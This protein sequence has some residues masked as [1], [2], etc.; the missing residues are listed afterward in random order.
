MAFS[1]DFLIRK[2][3]NYT[4]KEGVSMIKS[5]SIKLPDD[6]RVRTYGKYVY[7][8]IP[9]TWDG[10]R[11]HSTDDRKMIGKIDEEKPGYFLP[12]NIYYEFFPVADVNSLKEPD[13]MDTYLAAGPFLAL[14]SSLDKCGALKA[15]QSTFG[16]LAPEIQAFA[17]FMVDTEQGRA[18][19]Y[20]RWGFSNYAGIDHVFSTTGVSNLF[21]SIGN[22]DID[23]FMKAYGKNY[24]ESGIS[25][26]TLIL[27]FDSTNVNTHSDSIQFAEFGHP[28]KKEKLPSMCTAMGVDEETG[29]PLYYED[30]VGSLL[31]KTQM[32]FTNMKL[33][34]LGF[35]NVFFVFDRGYY[36][37]T[38]FG[39]SMN[40]NKFVIL[41]P[42]T[43][44]TS[45]DYIRENGFVIKDSERYYLDSVEAYGIQLESDRFMGR[46]LYTYIYYDPDT[47]RQSI[48]TLHA[49]IRNVMEK[50]GTQ[51][52]DEDVASQNHAYMTLSRSENGGYSI[53]KNIAEIQDEIDFA[54]FFMAVSNE[55]LTPEEMLKRIR[56]RD[57]AEKTFL[58]MK[59]FLDSEKSYCH[60]T[61]TYRGRNFVVFIALVAKLSFRYLESSLLKFDSTFSNDTTGTLLAETAKLI[62]CRN[63]K[64]IYEQR[65]ALTSK[66]KK[67]FKNLGIKQEQITEY[68]TNTLSK[69][70]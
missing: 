24:R 61:E 7:Y 56:R 53:E 41:V 36:N 13:T 23:K 57:C 5:Q 37:K 69:S 70:V 16:N 21:A 59:S 60:R 33:K 12:N 22:D 50:L 29:I 48:A 11:K 62:A 35:T 31:D 63:S 20:A 40:G 55:K 14:N 49:R 3:Y 44:T 27:A 26:N 66:M 1:I 34:E 47:A 32:S 18:Q 10:E 45:F 65:Y 2:A 68:L 39:D 51:D 25:K 8:K 30:F 4:L 54:G 15:L 52:Y 28:K 58:Q 64:G 17:T 42:D 38:N 43:V 67:V 9:S 19:K 6:K 46:K